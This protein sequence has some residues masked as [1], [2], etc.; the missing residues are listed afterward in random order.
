VTAHCVHDDEIIKYH[1]VLEWLADIADHD[2]E[3]AGIRGTIV[4][5]DG[6]TVESDQYQGE[7]S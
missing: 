5:S 7:I 2:E 6:K 3:D 1:R 4:L